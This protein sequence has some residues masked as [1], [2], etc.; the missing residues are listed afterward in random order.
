MS[1]VS[2]YFKKKSNLCSLE[3]KILNVNFKM[4]LGGCGI[5]SKLLSSI[6]FQWS[7]LRCWKYDK[8]RLS[9]A[10]TLINMGCAS[11]AI[12]YVGCVS[13]VLIL[14]GCPSVVLFCA[15]CTYML[16]IHVGCTSVTLI[17][18][19]CSSMALT[20]VGCV[21]LSCCYAT[22]ELNL[23]HLVFH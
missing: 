20:H 19:G 6:A 2:I 22:R 16:F 10:M 8:T 7:F 11:T 23:F 13:V 15:V 1:I 18:V 3:G 5:S 4:C 9:K 17:H 14:L 21:F 12:I